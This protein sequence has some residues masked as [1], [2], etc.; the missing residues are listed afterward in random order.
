MLGKPASSNLQVLA[1]RVI[2]QRFSPVG[3]LCNSK[4]DVLYV[5]GRVGK[6]LEPAIGRANL[7]LFAMAREGL[8]YNLSSAFAAAVREDRTVV[9]NGIKV[10]TNG[11]TQL[12]DLTIEKLTEPKGLRGTVLVLIRDTTEAAAGKAPKGRPAAARSPRVADLE[13]DLQH[14]R[15]EV[16]TTREEMQ[17]SQEELKSTNEELQST[18]EELQSTNEEPPPRRRRC[19]PSTRSCRR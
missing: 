12:I 6:Y 8:R 14:S 18:N 15:D 5:S 16:Q 3:V 13:Q 17:T 7:S 9:V 10:G 19:S 11:G 1:D 2:V 4:G